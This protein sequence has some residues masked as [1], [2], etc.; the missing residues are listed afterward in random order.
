MKRIYCLLLI[1]ILTNACNGYSYKG[2]CLLIP[3]HKEIP[4]FKSP[5]A[6]TKIDYIINDTINED[7]PLISIAEIVDSMAL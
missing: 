5:K 3:R 2:H 6:I 7:Y 4:L 1:I